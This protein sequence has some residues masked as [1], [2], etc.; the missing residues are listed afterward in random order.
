MAI[1]FAKLSSVKPRSK[2]VYM[3]SINDI[4]R[5]ELDRRS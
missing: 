5:Q 3:M 4:D 2:E 1:A